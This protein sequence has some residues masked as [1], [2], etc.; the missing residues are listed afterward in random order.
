MN[1]EV[2]ARLRLL[3][4]FLL[5]IYLL[6]LGFF[7]DNLWI[8]VYFYGV[9]L[10]SLFIYYLFYKKL[11]KESFLISLLD[12]FSIFLFLYIMKGM[13]IKFLFLI[14]LP[15][16]KEV[17]YK[18]F[19]HAY[20]LS[21]LSWIALFLFSIYIT[22]Y[23]PMQVSISILPFSFLITYVSIYYAKEKGG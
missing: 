20:L 21:L 15:I 3:I 23:I 16:I 6:S 9:F 11:L 1:D 13:E 12:E 2:I 19:K 14:F 7:F 8:R 10:Y 17:V 5:F 18:R 22:P 4:F